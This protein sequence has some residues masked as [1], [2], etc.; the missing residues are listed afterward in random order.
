MNVCSAALWCLKNNATAFSGR[1]GD[2]EVLSRLF[3]KR[4]QAEWP[5]Y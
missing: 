2:E 4:L 3:F 5:D 1:G